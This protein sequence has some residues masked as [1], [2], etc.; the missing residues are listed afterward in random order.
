MYAA[1]FRGDAYKDALYKA[2]N[3]TSGDRFKNAMKELQELDGS[4]Y[5]WVTEK[6]SSQWSK[7]FFSTMALCDMTLNNG[8]E[9]FNSMI[10]LAREKP[11]LVMLEWIR[12]YLMKRLHKNR[13]KVSVKAKWN[14]L[15]CPEAMEILQ[16]NMERVKYCR[17]LQCNN[18]HF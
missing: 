1:G 4:A 15:I 11:I 2:S 6:P 7:A 12:E 16:K 5:E 18:D 17:P 13:C 9:S 8:C 10:L 3:A 14:G